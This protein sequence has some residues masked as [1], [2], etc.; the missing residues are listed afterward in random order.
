MDE[1]TVA[2]RVNSEPLTLA[3]LKAVSVRG[4]AATVLAMAVD[5]KSVV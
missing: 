5:R 4:G 2:D 3:R 1:P